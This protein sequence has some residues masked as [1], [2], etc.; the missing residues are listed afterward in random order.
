[1]IYNFIIRTLFFG[2]FL[3]SFVSNAQ[4]VK[5]PK[6]SLN[7]VHITSKGNGYM[8]LKF[9]FSDNT[10]HD[11]DKG[12]VF[13]EDRK[14]SNFTISIDGGYF[15]K[16][17]W[18]VGG[19]LE[20]GKSERKGNEINSQGITNQIASVN[21][22]F[23]VFGSTKN[24]I[25]LDKRNIFYMYNLLYLGGEFRKSLDETTSDALLTRTMKKSELIA[26]RIEPGIMVNIIRGFTVEAG[27]EIAGIQA[28]WTKREVNGI[29]AGRTNS[30]SGDLTINLL[31]FNLGLYYYF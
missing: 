15:I 20:I 28:Q 10:V 13:I 27:T 8:G 18:A 31:K 29:A 3:V 16:K 9:K 26:L 25:P 14:A 11:T 7:A 6:D 23:G 22:V 5:N 4:A 12:F 17:N 19:L 24:I 2:T 21:E 30:F 1:M